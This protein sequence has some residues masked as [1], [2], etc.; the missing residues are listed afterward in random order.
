M[1]LFTFQ[2]PSWNSVFW[3][4]NT[5]IFF[6]FSLQNNRNFMCYMIIQIKSNPENNKSI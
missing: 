1:T 2:N 6:S 4:F 5:S 3:V